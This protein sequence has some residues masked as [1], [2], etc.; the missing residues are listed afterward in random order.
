MP[1]FINP[2]SDE[3]SVILTRAEYNH[4]MDELDFLDALRATG[5]YNWEG[6]EEALKFYDAIEE[7]PILKDNE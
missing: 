4:M 7:N 1:K 6:Y 3:D 2:S 5:V